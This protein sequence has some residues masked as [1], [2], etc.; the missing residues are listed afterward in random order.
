MIEL[1]CPWCQ[2][3]SRLDFSAFGAETCTLR[4]EGCGVE[5]TVGD[6]PS[7]ALAAVAA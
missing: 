6:Q 1:E 2:E 3:P 4:C 7:E 5:V